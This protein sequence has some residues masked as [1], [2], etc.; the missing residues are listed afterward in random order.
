MQGPLY[1][2]LL[3]NGFSAFQSNY[4]FE[5]LIQFRL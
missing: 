2:D 5:I 3:K 1:V 4:Y